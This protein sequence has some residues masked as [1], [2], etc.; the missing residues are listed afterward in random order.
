MCKSIITQV[1]L[2]S[3]KRLD[4][5]K[6]TAMYLVGNTQSLTDAYKFGIELN[7]VLPLQYSLGGLYL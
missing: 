2:H 1:M 7:D 5:K 6:R 3:I 4:I